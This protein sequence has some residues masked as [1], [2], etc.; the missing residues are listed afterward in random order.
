M[1]PD[2][3][4]KNIELVKLTRI[5]ILLMLV[6]LQDI[7]FNVATFMGALSEYYFSIS[8]TIMFI[9]ISELF[10]NI[11]FSCYSIRFFVLPTPHSEK[12]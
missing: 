8:L 11:Y 6:P 4:D 5:I 3:L 12:Q 7:Y 9:F 10:Y 2:D 1:K